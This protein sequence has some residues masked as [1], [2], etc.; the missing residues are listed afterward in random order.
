MKALNIGLIGAGA[1][2][3]FYAGHMARQGANVSIISR[4]PKDYS[5]PIEIVSK[6]DPFQFSPT[7]IYSLSDDVPSFDVL[8]LATKVLPDLDPVQLIRPFV[9]KN[10]VILLIQN[11]V[12][13][14]ANLMAAFSNPIIR[15]LAFVCAHRQSK[16]RIQ[17]LDF[18]S[19]TIGLMSGSIDV[20]HAHP[21]IQFLKKLPIKVHLS[22]NIQQSIWEKLVWNAA[23][24]PLSVYYKGLDTD[25]L[26]NHE[27]AF[28]AIQAIMKEVQAGA[29]IQNIDLS[30]QFLADKITQ[31][32]KMMP[33]K[34]SMCLD[35][36]QKRPLE[37][38]AI[39]GNFIRFCRKHQVPTPISQ[40]I[41]T[42]LKH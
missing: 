26:L 5:G 32:R 12:F 13:I 29:R 42:A 41:Y 37:I 6:T 21:F 15:S 22:D 35:Y 3:C 30:D 7:A 28:Y 36:E 2:G 34:T 1:V 8:I 25:A 38:D 27:E 18:G 14:E 10:T 17:H 39:L 4:A 23:F 33:Y 19:I 24:N 40:T 31:T 20:Y 11:G 9:T 16:M